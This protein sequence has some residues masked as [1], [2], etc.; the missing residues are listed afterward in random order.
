MLIKEVNINKSFETAS[1][2]KFRMVKK[3]KNYIYFINLMTKKIHKQSLEA[4]NC[5]VF[6]VK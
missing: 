3:D 4:A 1:G 6:N 2:E 5:D